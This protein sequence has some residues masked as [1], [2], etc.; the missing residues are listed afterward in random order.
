MCMHEETK[1]MS[2][3]YDI[4]VLHRPRKC[5]PSQ[6]SEH[7]P[8]YSC[9][10]QRQCRDHNGTW[11]YRPDALRPESHAC[12]YQKVSRVY[13]RAQERGYKKQAEIASVFY[14]TVNQCL[15]I[16]SCRGPFYHLFVSQQDYWGSFGKQLT[17]WKSEFVQIISGII[18]FV[19]NLDKMNN[20]NSDST[21]RNSKHLHFWQYPSLLQVRPLMLGTLLIF[22]PR[23]AYQS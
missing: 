11:K 18:C 16:A 12:A 13:E 4:P 7:Q 10:L 5:H 6:A 22:A 14:C 8:I 15:A 20:L 21:K 23:Q 19:I 2:T 3:F 17:H 1:H 9:V